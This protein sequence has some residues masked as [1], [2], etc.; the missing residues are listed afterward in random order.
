MV[1]SRPRAS[2]R[3]SL[4]PLIEELRRIHKGITQGGAH[5]PSLMHAYS[6]GFL[7]DPAAPSVKPCLQ[8][9]VQTVPKLKT[10]V[11]PG[12]KPSFCIVKRGLVTFCNSK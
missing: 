8:T 11:C 4:Q 10:A 2:W 6:S 3:R 9:K 7:Q 1:L 12:Q 5:L